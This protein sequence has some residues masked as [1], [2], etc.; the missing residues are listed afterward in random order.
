MYENLSFEFAALRCTYTCVSC[1]NVFRVVF[2]KHTYK[3]CLET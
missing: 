3:V 1:L 2:T